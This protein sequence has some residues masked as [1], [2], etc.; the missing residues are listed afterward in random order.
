MPYSVESH[1]GFLFADEQF[2]EYLAQVDELLC[3]IYKDTIN[4][5]LH[6]E[7]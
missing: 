3:N 5:I 1:L 4:I 6:S 2:K 7:E